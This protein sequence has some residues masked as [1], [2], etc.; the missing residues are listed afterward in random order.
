MRLLKE[1]TIIVLLFLSAVFILLI[2]FFGI[3]STP[4]ETKIDSTSLVENYQFINLHRSVSSLDSIQ[5]IAF[6]TDSNFIVINNIVIN[7]TRRTFGQKPELGFYQEYYDE[8]NKNPYKSL[9]SLF[10][11]HDIR[12]DSSWAL[13][14]IHDMKK[15]GIKDIS[16]SEGKIIYR[17]KVSAMYGEE[18][19]IYAKERINKD[20]TRFD[21]L[22]KLN[23]N[24]Y[25]FAVYR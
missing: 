7:T 13:T 25:H 6:L 16:I 10:T 1:I 12:L 23:N 5:N 9:N 24:F 18:G 19:I 20:S 15:T 4:K 22:E 8:G 3:I 14:T 2:I 17:W 11:S 21:L